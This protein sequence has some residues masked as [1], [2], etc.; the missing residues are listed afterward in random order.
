MMMGEMWASNIA[1]KIEKKG[2]VDLFHDDSEKMK[3]ASCAWVYTRWGKIVFVIGTFVVLFVFLK[4]SHPHAQ[5]LYTQNQDEI[6]SRIDPYTDQLSNHR[7]VE[8]FA[9]WVDGTVSDAQTEAKEYFTEQKSQ[10]LSAARDFEVH[11][12]FLKIMLENGNLETDMSLYDLMSLR[13]RKMRDLQETRDDF[14]VAFDKCEMIRFFQR[15]DVPV[16]K[17]GK[18]WQGDD[19]KEDLVR[20]FSK[21][22]TGGD[23]KRLLTSSTAG[24]LRSCH[25]FDGEL[26][27]TIDV[28]VR[29]GQFHHGS[30]RPVDLSSESTDFTPHSRQQTARWISHEWNAKSFDYTHT[31]SPANNEM[32]N[33]VTSGFYFQSRV[34]CDSSDKSLS[35]DPNSY[36]HLSIEVVWGMPYL[37]TEAL[38]DKHIIYLRDSSHVRADDADWSPRVEVYQ[39]QYSKTVHSPTARELPTESHGWLTKRHLDCAWNLAKDTATKVRADQ[40]RVDVFVP[41]DSPQG[42]LVDTIV[43]TDPQFQG[44]HGRYIANLWTTPYLE[45]LYR[46]ASRIESGDITFNMAGV[47]TVYA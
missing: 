3:D 12:Y 18:I 34:G 30:I 29:D 7:Y 15:H 20:V 2:W 22:E 28:S 9:S 43:L 13:T 33:R 19:E 6:H 5:R 39:G 4:V 27:K 47:S 21:E 16:P 45:K 32:A 1:K 10:V 40:L 44:V 14:R 8:N 26:F 41:R 17:V 24:L 31:W 35:C 46:D 38:E 36:L 42:C 25:K 37:A 11:P 23:A